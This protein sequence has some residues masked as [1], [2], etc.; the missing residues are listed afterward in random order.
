MEKS[1]RW[2]TR[3]PY[4]ALIAGLCAGMAAAASVALAKGGDPDR[5]FGGDG[6]VVTSFGPGN[7]AARAIAIRGDGRIVVGG[8]TG[9]NAAPSF[10]L[11]RYLPN[12]ALDSSFGGGDGKVVVPVGNTNPVA[13]GITAIKLQG[14]GKIVA[15]G[16]TDDQDWLVMRFLPGGAPDGSFGGGDGGTQLDLG[17]AD[18]P[19]DVTVLPSGDILVAGY[20]GANYA[21]ARFN[22]NGSPDSGFNGDGNGDGYVKF[23]FGG[24]SLADFGLAL[25]PSSGGKF[26][27]AGQADTPEGGPTTRFEYD[28]G[29]ARFHANG[30]LDTSF[31]GGDARVS[32][33]FNPAGDEMEHEEAHDVV[34]RSDGRIVVVGQTPSGFGVARLTPGGSLDTS[35]HF[36]GRVVVP[37]GTVG[38]AR[39]V[40]IQSS[41]KLV[42]AGD[43]GLQQ[44]AIARLSSN[45][46]L[47]GSFGGGDGIALTNFGDYDA[48][49]AMALGPNG[50]PVVAGVVQPGSTLDWGLARYLN[51]G[52]RR[53]AGKI[54]TIVATRG[55]V[56]GTQGPDVI[57]A[58]KG[59]QK[60]RGG[61]GN[62]VICTGGGRDVANGGPGNDRIFGGAGNDTLGGSA[63]ND[64]LFGQKGRDRMKG[65][66]GRDLC[67][68]GPGRD[69]ARSCERRRSL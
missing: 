23:H 59:R 29:V 17:G 25:A 9:T 2:G 33:S 31:G 55:R 45:G 27:V 43:R 16:N 38:S 15:V 26:V 62:D 30:L 44:F 67:V 35:F 47:D 14:D 24:G 19:R 64:R 60:I 4:V 51:G 63:G 69:R 22:P 50:R 46:F 39:D 37:M 8:E 42:V 5:S 65:A 48:G 49:R 32:F 53:C 58:G 1:R 21:M 11:A 61:G 18:T 57:W 40:A 52:D 28:F 66:A 6:K 12:G 68:G 34:V 54:A 3:R 13:Y 20:S 56:D 36:D 41:G 10:A 7:E